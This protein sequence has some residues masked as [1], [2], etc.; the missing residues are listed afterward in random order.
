MEIFSVKTNARKTLAKQ[1]GLYTNRLVETLSR[2][3][4]FTDFFTNIFF[5]YILILW[6][7]SFLFFK[8]KVK[9]KHSSS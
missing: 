3:T 4:V 2:M 8:F 9:P 5:I 1:K 7:F 6:D